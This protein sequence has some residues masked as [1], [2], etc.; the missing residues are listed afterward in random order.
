MSDPAYL[1]KLQAQQ[2]EF[3]CS[4]INVTSQDGNL[5][6]TMNCSQKV[7]NLKITGTMKYLGK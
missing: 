1:K 3:G 2:E 5:A 7:G 6:G 4:T